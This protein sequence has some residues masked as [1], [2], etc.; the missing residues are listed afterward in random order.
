MRA[1]AKALP[2]FSSAPGRSNPPVLDAAEE[3]LEERGGMKGVQANERTEQAAAGSGRGAQQAS[4]AVREERSGRAAASAMHDA[5]PVMAV[6]HARAAVAWVVT[7]RIMLREG[8]R[9]VTEGSSDDHT[10]KQKRCVR[11]AHSFCSHSSLDPV[12]SNAPDIEARSTG[13]APTRGKEKTRRCET[14]GAMTASSLSA[15]SAGEEHKTEERT[16]NA[17]DQRVVHA[18][19]GCA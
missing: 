19:R 4:V 12:H 16:R 13:Q 10:S 7:I 8:G 11:H 14:A 9:G 15:S 2:S 1:L 6:L 3:K 17:E 5:D 18:L